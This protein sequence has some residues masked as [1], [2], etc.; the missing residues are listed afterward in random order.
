MA[1]DTKIEWADHTF[2]P[3]RGCT[4][5][6]AACDH[7]YAERLVN[8]RL[9]GDFSQRV[10]AASSTWQE[11]RRW[12][13]AAARE[14]KRA[15]VFTASLADVFDNRVPGEWREDLWALIHDTPNLDWLLLT[16][17]P[18]NIGRM[19]PGSFPVD[20][21]DGHAAQVWG[22]GWPN[23]CLGTTVENQ[24]VAASRIHHLGRVPARV[25]FLSCEP[26][27]G[28]VRF[29]GIFGIPP[30]NRI[31]HWVI[32]GGE[33]GPGARPMHPDWA[34]SLRDQCAA[35]GLA[36]HFKQW[37][38]WHT[39]AF[40]ASTG[41]AVFRQF[42]DFQHWVA[43]A[44][45]WV[46]GGVCLDTKGRELKMGAHFARARDEGCFPVTIMHRVG[47]KAA[48]R[49]LDGAQHDGVPDA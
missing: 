10:R 11:P 24:D 26:L 46:R 35:A 31:I 25:R 47:K 40:S 9:A 21:R 42:R 28:D 32:A 12:N 23:V 2:N 13:R 16:K 17:R 30:W 6:S 5:V 4:K 38:E 37:G 18:Q 36:F 33:S 1:A 3:W 19:L 48:G 44:T 41:E 20:G 45:T 39:A 15:R 7:C 43:K 22:A 29:T 8:G 34:R 14:G 49:L 27:L